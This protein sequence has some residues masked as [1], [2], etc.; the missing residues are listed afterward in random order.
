MKP[1]KLAGAARWYRA[2]GN[3]EVAEDLEFVLAKKGRCKRCGRLVTDPRS[4][5]DSIGPE[6]RRKDQPPALR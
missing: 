5:V 3:V 1:T 4:V 6:C 2:Q